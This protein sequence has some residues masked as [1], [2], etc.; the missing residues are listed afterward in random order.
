[1]KRLIFIG[2]ILLLALSA[3]HSPRR[4]ACL[5]V[6]RAEH[7]ADTLPD[8]TLCFGQI[9]QRGQEKTTQHLI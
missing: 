5:M 4:E 3:C 7:L 6:R 2:L 1:M 8:S 9:A